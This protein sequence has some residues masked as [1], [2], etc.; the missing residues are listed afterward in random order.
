VVD[1]AVA[2]I[3]LDKASFK[4]IKVVQ[5]SDKTRDVHFRHLNNLAEW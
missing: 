1:L 5:S 4:P 3:V 2:V